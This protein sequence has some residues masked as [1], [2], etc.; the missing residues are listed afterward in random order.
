MVHALAYYDKLTGL[1]SRAY[2][3]E[4]ME[5]NIKNA[6]RKN[7]S[8]AFLYLDLDGFKDVNDSYGHNIGDLYLKAVAERIRSVVREVDFA[9]RLGGDEFCILVDNIT[10]EQ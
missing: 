6:R 10:G 8:F 1:A 3:Q 2:F 9:A 5:H 7:E 4:R